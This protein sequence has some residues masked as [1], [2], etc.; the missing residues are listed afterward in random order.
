MNSGFEKFQPTLT[1][2]QVE[3]YLLYWSRKG[4]RVVYGREPLV[5]GW[6]VF[7]KP[8]C[9]VGIRPGQCPGYWSVHVGHLL[10]SIGA[11]GTLEELKQY[12][13]TACASQEI[14]LEALP[15]QHHTTAEEPLT[16]WIKL[17]SMIGSAQITA[18]WDPFLTSESIANLRD[19]KGLGCNFSKNLRLLTSSTGSLSKNFVDKFN[20]EMGIATELRY[21]QKK[22]VRVIFLN[23]GR[24]I[25]PDF[26]LNKEQLGTIS[27]VETAPKLA[28]FELEW[29]T[30]N[31]A[32]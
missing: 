29:K 28:L 22:H 10:R 21:G 31:P 23:D 1:Q 30:A 3:G 8:M 6:T 19:L 25:S 14:S 2:D 15:S 27:V 12:F 11:I 20:F 7:F 26:S 4:Y 24:C 9:M 16:F 13:E 5:N 32:I 17:K 18:I